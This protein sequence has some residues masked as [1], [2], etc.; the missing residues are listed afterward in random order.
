MFK[1]FIES[2]EHAFFHFQAISIYEVEIKQLKADIAKLEKRVGKYKRFWQDNRS[3]EE[4]RT[5]D[6]QRRILYDKV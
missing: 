5:E 2:S 3:I 4:M 6:E 1:Y